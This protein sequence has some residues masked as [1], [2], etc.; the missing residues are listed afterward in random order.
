MNTNSLSM[1]LGAKTSYVQLIFLVLGGMEERHLKIQVE[2]DLTKPLQRGTKLRFKE[3][4]TWVDFK[5][6]HAPNFCYYSG[7]IGHN[8]KLCLKRKH[9]AERNCLL[10]DQFGIWLRAE[11]KRNER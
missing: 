11:G 5:Y 6:A 1:I 8:E 4:E 10:K 7:H 9:D 3:T 2:V